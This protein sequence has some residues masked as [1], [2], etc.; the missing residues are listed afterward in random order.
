MIK[1]IVFD[2]GKVLVAYDTYKVCRKFIESKEDIELVNT[3]VFISP[4]WLLLD[5]GLLE[6]ADAI[7]IM[8]KRLPKRL[9][10]A[11]RSC[12]AHWHEYCMSPI[13]EM[14]NLVTRLKELGYGIYLCSNASVRLLT[15]YQKVIP[16]IE[17]FDGILFSAQV[18]CLKPQKYIYEEL[19]NKFQLDP[20]TCFFID[21]MAL[22]IEGSRA[23]G[24][25]GYCFADG[26]VDKLISHLAQLL[27][28]DL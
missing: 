1:N 18:K 19:Y 16:S 9:H 3:A 6:E 25:D 2:M 8:C 13:I 11:A 21:D 22:N 14:G 12:F 4:E 10:E 28:E 7:E 24:M 17:L 5:M 23:T 27:K 20:S 15:C 26:D